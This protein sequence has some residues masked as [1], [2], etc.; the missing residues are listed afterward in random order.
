MLSLEMPDPA[1]PKI[2]WIASLSV[3]RR[4]GDARQSQA[5]ANQTILKP[6]APLARGLF[7]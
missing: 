7:I 4:N 2:P 6:K 5:T 1:I 3:Q